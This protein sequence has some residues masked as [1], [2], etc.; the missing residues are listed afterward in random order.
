MHGIMIFFCDLLMPA[1]ARGTKKQILI[2]CTTLDA[3]VPIY[4]VTPER[5]GV[6]RD[7]DVPVCLAYNQLHYESLIPMS[8]SDIEKLK[9]LVRKVLDESYEY[10]QKD[11]AWLIAAWTE[12]ERKQRNR[13][14][15]TEKREE[16]KAANTV[17]KQSKRKKDP[18]GYAKEKAKITVQRKEKRERSP[19][20]YTKEKA[21]ITVQQKEKRKKNPAGYTKVKATITVQQKANRKKDPAGYAKEKA[22]II[23]QKN[24]KKS[25]EFQSLLERDT[26]FEL[27][28]CICLEYKSQD[29]VTNIT[30]IPLSVVKQHC[31]R[32]NTTLSTG[33]ENYACNNCRARIRQKEGSKN[34]SKSFFK[35]SD[36]PKSLDD[37]IANQ[38]GSGVKTTLNKL[39]AFI[40]KLIIPF[41]RVAHCPRGQYLQVRGNLILISS[42]IASSLKKIIPIEDQQILPVTFKRKLQYD[43]HYLAEWID[44]KKIEI[45]FNWLKINNHLYKDIDF[46]TDSLDKIIDTCNESLEPMPLPVGPE[47]KEDDQWDRDGEL[48]D[49]IDSIFSEFVDLQGEDGEGFEQPE[50]VEAWQQYST[51]MKNKYD[52]DIDSHTWANHYAGTII[53]LEENHQISKPL[54]I[55]DNIM[56]E[57]NDDF[58]SEDIL[59]NQKNVHDEIVAIDDS[60][61][62]QQRENIQQYLDNENAEE[63]RGEKQK[64]KRCKKKNYYILVEIILR[65]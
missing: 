27:I 62:I 52:E 11:I 1:I 15:N 48:D 42:D 58:F 3:P 41:V 36:F 29:K 17:Q 60:E 61:N 2:F 9:H 44:R 34:S 45:Y 5:F 16:E 19:A 55:P 25:L 49:E 13:M 24:K 12:A 40:L 4:V 21:T 22:K 57:D 39:E 30:N 6:D 14:I 63:T 32:N 8:P 59:Y 51:L 56:N 35:N 33:G 18:E 53:Y 38:L 7:S 65:L 28:C 23:D 50:K 64:S 31:I 43:G 46:S 47:N 10:K 37:E 26:G 54:D 20:G